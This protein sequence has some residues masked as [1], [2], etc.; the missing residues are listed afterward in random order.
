ML[1]VN[2]D[3]SPLM[4]WHERLGHLKVASIKD[5]M[6]NG[7]F[8][9]LA[10]PKE[11]FKKKFVCR[12]CMSAKQKRRSYKKSADEKRR[13]VNYEQL[14]SDTCDM[15]NYLP[16]LSSFKYF[17]LIQGGGLRYKR[18]FPLKEKSEANAN[19]KR[20]MTE[21]LEQGHRVKTFSS[22]GGGEFV[23]RELLVFWRG[24]EFDSCP[25]IRIHR[26]ETR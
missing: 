16:G 3:A 6:E 2:A 21:L 7:T 5:M 15:G 26:R 13:K 22:D 8:T 14:M 20:L 24:G 10:I 11:L 1:T 19:T 18:C 25:G 9:G 4:R 23:N 17:Q 12:S